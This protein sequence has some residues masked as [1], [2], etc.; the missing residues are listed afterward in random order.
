MKG[1][2]GLLPRRAARGMVPTD[3]AP[4]GAGTSPRGPTRRPAAPP[5]SHGNASTG[6]SRGAAPPRMDDR[7]RLK[8][9][10]VL[11]LI[12]ATLAGAG[13]LRIGAGAMALAEAPAEIAEAPQP[14]APD[15]AALLEALR[16]RS[17]Q[18]D[19]REQ[20]LA[21]RE[22]AAALAGVQID[23][24]LRQLTEAEDRLAS[25]LAMA[26]RAADKDVMQLVAM[27]EAMKSKQAAL[28]FEQ[29][30]P[31]FAAGFLGRMQPGPAGA[32]LADMDPKA[33][34]AV[35]VILAGRNA[36]APQQ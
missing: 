27:Y 16:L 28:L 8:G 7:R 25:T 14:P 29:M 32:V 19:R 35:S 21:D 36:M 1:L 17:A 23:G 10:G 30:P 11:A 22:Q 2:A 6:A 33:A 12:A 18:L 20:E 31:E 9:R 24:K 5:P 15:S 4:Q 26:D 13:V 3:A 34:Y